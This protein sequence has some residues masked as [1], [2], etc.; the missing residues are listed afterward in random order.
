MRVMSTKEG[1]IPIAIVRT[2]ITSFSTAL[3]KEQRCILPVVRGIQI[4]IPDAISE[5]SCGILYLAILGSQGRMIVARTWNP[6]F[7]L[8]VLI[9]RSIFARLHP[10]EEVC[11]QLRLQ[12][13]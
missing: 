11:C 7:W 13:Q 8:P 3:L 6:K 4:A 10:K 2:K 5:A 12:W 9:S 1:T